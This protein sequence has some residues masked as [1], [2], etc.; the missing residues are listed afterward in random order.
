MKQMMVCVLFALAVQATG[1]KDQDS[2]SP[3]GN[4]NPKFTLTSFAASQSCSTCHPQYYREW[5]GSMHRY[6][7]NDP[8][9]M[10]ASNGL[11]A[12]TQGK[13]KDWCWQC[14][15]PIAFLSGTTL[16]TFQISQLPEIVREGVNCDV[17]HTL[18][19]PHTTSNQ[20][21]TY[22][23]EP[24][25]DKFGTLSSP[26]STSAHGS[27]YDAS[28]GRSEVCRGCHDLIVN[29]LPAEVT[30]TEWQNSAWG[31]M[32]VECQNCHMRKYSGQAA[33]GGPVRQNLHRHDFVGVDLAMTD[34]PNKAEQRAAVDSLLKNSASMN[35]EAPT[36][37]S[38]NDSIRLIVRVTNDKTGH[39]IPTSV[40]FFRQMW[41]DVTVFSGTDTVY[42]SGSLDANG[43]LMDR[44]SAL[45]PNADRDLMLFSGYLFKHGVESNVFELDSI[46]NTSLAP[47]AT[48]A[49]NH[50][51]RVPRAGTWNVK[52][53]LLFRPFGPYLFRAV[54]GEQYIREIPTFEIAA[55]EAGIQV[56]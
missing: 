13:L 47:F 51:F 52:V 12:S 38:I 7:A 39:N 6:A 32:S 26:V 53:R 41:V 42:R 44:H 4:E 48:R 45:A 17:C 36:V 2:P 23:I 9:W 27:V 15:V 33:V 55:A 8:I 1:C 19:P 11:Q 20:H 35:I 50:K 25:R 22:N 21:I 10:L 30:F 24:G 14:H 56:N 31:A 34:F 43:D 3:A 37:A 40:S 5:E 54:G 18:R 16:P 49:G 46:Q 28:Y 29:N